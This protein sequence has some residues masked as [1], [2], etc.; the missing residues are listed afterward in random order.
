MNP[1][2]EYIQIISKIYILYKDCKMSF[3]DELKNINLMQEA[4]SNKL[5]ENGVSISKEELDKRHIHYMRRDPITG[6]LESVASTLQKEW[7]ERLSA[8]GENI[9]FIGNMCLVLFYQYWDDHYR[10]EIAKYKGYSGENKIQSDLFGEI[11][12]I[13]NSII[14]HNS[15]AKYEVSK[16]K[17]LQWFTEGEEIIIDDLKMEQ[18]YILIKAELVKFQ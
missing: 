17:L 9:N 15:I 10:K 18:L 2:E 4:S 5:I 3:Y 11:R 16:C 13:R 12:H 8:S 6:Q 1:V 14:H 7:K